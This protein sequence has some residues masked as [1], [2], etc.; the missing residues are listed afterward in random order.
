MQSWTL[1][2]SLFFM[3]QETGTAARVD[4]LP[5]VTEIAT[6]ELCE[7]ARK[8]WVKANTEVATEPTTDY[9]APDDNPKAKQPTKDQW[10]LVTPIAVCIR[11]R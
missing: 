8:A 7:S 3:Q 1:I 10:Q 9:E 6:E 5:P 11:V 2:L 4:H